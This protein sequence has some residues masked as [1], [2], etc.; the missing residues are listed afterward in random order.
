MSTR[1]MKLQKYLIIFLTI[2]MSLGKS[3]SSEIIET[4]IGR[5][6]YYCACSDA[7]LVID[8]PRLQDIKVIPYDHAPKV[9]DGFTSRTEYTLRGLPFKPRAFWE[10]TMNEQLIYL[11]KAIL[12]CGLLPLIDKH[13]DGRCLYAVSY[14]TQ[15]AGN[16][17][18]KKLE[19]E[20]EKAVHKILETEYDISFEDFKHS[21][22]CML[23]SEDTL[24]SAPLI[25][26][27]ADKLAPRYEFHYTSD[28][29]TLNKVVKLP[30]EFELAI[31][32]SGEGK[33]I[34]EAKK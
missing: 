30:S 19:E 8:A 5:D 17:Y 26:Y 34:Y 2:V 4:K 16:P 18:P 31:G 9:P 20:F 28:D 14:S 11:K 6:W 29:Q 21:I 1:I 23:I 7:A 10:K 25:V 27:F 13:Y 15:P 32:V 22:Y 24:Y 12:D 3:I 33:I